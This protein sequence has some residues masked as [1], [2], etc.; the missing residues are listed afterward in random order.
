MLVYWTHCLPVVLRYMSAPPSLPSAPLAVHPRI[1]SLALQLKYKQTIAGRETDR[2]EA[3]HRLSIWGMPC[4][5]D[6]ILTPAG[7]ADLDF[8]VLGSV[9]SL[10]LLRPECI[11]L[12]TDALSALQSL[13]SVSTHTETRVYPSTLYNSIGLMKKYVEWKRTAYRTIKLHC[14]LVNKHWQPLCKLAHSEASFH[15][16]SRRSEVKTGSIM[17]K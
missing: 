5:Q 3:Y 8:N 7:R 15:S 6:H 4:R 9:P 17:S 13:L 10:W 11:L 12:Q 1:S 2:Y 16:H 14:A